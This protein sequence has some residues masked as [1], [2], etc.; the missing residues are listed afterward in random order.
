[1]QSSAYALPPW[2]GLALTVLVC[3]AAFWKGGREEQIAAGGLLLGWI[4]TLVLRDPR[5]DGAQVGAFVVDGAFLALLTALALRSDRYWPIATAGFQLLAVTTHAARV[6]D[7][8][9]SGW[10]Y[11][12]A[13]VIWTQL[14]LVALAVGV[15]GTWRARGRAVAA[16]GLEALQR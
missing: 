11:A 16:Q 10:A 6:L 9:L 3:G 15:W 5:W 2:F 8:H 14:V 1:L 12:T 13:E 7:K 4:A